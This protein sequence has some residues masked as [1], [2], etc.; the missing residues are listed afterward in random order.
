MLDGQDKYTGKRLVRS[1]RCLI[2]RTPWPPGEANPRRLYCPGECKRKARRAYKRRWLQKRKGIS[3][4]KCQVCGSR[5]MMD[6]HRRR[7]CSKECFHA[8]LLEYWRKRR[9]MLSN[10]NREKMR[11]RTRRYRASERGKEKIRQ[12][13]EKPEVKARRSLL[14]HARDEARER[15]IEPRDLLLE[16]GA[17]VGRVGVMRKECES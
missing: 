17:D 16:W 6:D 14:A 9:Q 1:D 12:W 7:Y 13:Q 8:A 3:D 4:R 5:W 2:C 15:G 10:A 11:D